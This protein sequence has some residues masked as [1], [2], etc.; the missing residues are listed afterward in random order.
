MIR[1]AHPEYFLWLL[2]LL[3]LAA[4]YWY[5]WYRKLRSIRAY[6]DEQTMLSLV[7]E[8]SRVKHW[9]RAGIMLFS[10]ALLV[11]A[12]AR[13]QIGTRY[14]EV[15]RQGVDLIVA[16][17]VSA[18]MLAQD[19]RP[20]RIDAAKRELTTLIEG[21]TGDRIGIIVFAGSSYTQLPLTT[22]YS[23]ASMLSDIISVGSAPTPGT[24][25]GSAITLAL[26]SFEKEEG[27]YK[28]MIIITD[29]EN[30][31]DDAL[32]VAKDAASKGVVIH[33]I[34]MG[35]ADGAPIPVGEG[36]EN[37]GFKT[38]PDGGKIVSKLDESTLRGIADATG[39][40]YVRASNSRDDLA[41]VFKEVE[42]MEKKEFG[43]KQFTNYED[44]FQYPLGL[45][46][47]LLVYELLLSEKRNRFLSRF[48][49]FAPER[50]LR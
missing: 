23:A 38:G 33:T 36:E 15:K 20:S 50:T 4:L 16:L 39:G 19:I 6:G 35:S 11:L 1:F 21:L 40:I 44:R 47:L 12:M 37:M 17:D 10:A 46:L 34:G 8:R 24:A 27:K 9:L 2:L 29:G 22:D 45:A 30:H 7:A 13:P 26:E 32:S 3:P 31:E 41:A 42:K 49:I 48:R 28:A 43:T 14:E 18:S 5:V 25:I